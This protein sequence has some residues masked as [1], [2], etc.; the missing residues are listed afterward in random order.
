MNKPYLDLVLGLG[1]FDSPLNLT[2][3]DQR[4]TFPLQKVGFW[5]LLDTA[6]LQRKLFPLG[7]PSQVLGRIKSS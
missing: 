7:P 6:Q 5:K 2:Q 4:K 1:T 3:S